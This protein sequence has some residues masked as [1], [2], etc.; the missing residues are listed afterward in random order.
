MNSLQ[1]VVGTVS[2]VVS[3]SVT[4]SL[5]SRVL[6]LE[7][8]VAAQKAIGQVYWSHR[9]WPADNPGPKPPLEAVMSDAEIRAKVED[10]LRKSAAIELHWR[11]RIS[12]ADLQIELNRIARDTRDGAMLKELFG[13]LD[14][15]PVLIGECLV[16]PIL[17]D[18]VVRKFFEDDEARIAS[19]ARTFDDWW[20]RAAEG[21][22]AESPSVE[23]ASLS[24]PE[25][26]LTACT[27]DT[28]APTKQDI[29]DPR[30]E[31]TAVWTGSEMLI[32]GGN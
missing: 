15:D 30:I 11:Q 5:A 1:R 8:R 9:I 21:F 6:T 31:H 19:S 24:V 12:P 29:P 13:A 26:A 25:P 10:G 18:R 3:L 14:N 22:S 17:A 7:D 16:R 20:S 4:P 27:D 32:F 28:W 2:V 23:A